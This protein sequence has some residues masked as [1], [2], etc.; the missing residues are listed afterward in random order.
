MRESRRF[1]VRAVR[2]PSLTETLQVLL[3]ANEKKL[4]N[5]FT[6]N[7]FKHKT[8][9]SSLSE[10]GERHCFIHSA[11]TLPTC[12][13]TNTLGAYRDQSGSRLGCSLAGNRFVPLKALE[14]MSQRHG[15]LVLSRFGI[16]MKRLRERG[17][18]HHASMLCLLAVVKPDAQSEA[19]AAS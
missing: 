1:S 4:Q 17:S 18:L 15:D 3:G 7:G 14:G 2:S 12:V 6:G 11:G 8:A 16:N 9:V 19:G 13:N 10:A 5:C